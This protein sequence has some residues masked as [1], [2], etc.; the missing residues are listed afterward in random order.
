MR[1]RLLTDAMEGPPCRTHVVL[2]PWPHIPGSCPMSTPQGAPATAALCA[3]CSWSPAKCEHC[4][5]HSQLGSIRG[6]P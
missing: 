1:G 5:K 3:R 2:D 4:L 6:F